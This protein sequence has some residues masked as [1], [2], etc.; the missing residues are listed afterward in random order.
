MNFQ[1][2]ISE[3]FQALEVTQNIFVALVALQGSNFIMAI[4]AMASGKGKTELLFYL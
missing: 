1:N 4:V 3:H 2:Y